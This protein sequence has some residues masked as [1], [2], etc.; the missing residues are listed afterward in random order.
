MHSPAAFFEMRL[1]S[2][3]AASEPRED[4]EDKHFSFVQEL[5]AVLATHEESFSAAGG[6]G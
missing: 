1:G 3:A 5:S 6:A 2:L 4:S